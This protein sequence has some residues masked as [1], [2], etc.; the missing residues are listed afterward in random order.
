MCFHMGDTH[1]RHFPRVF[2]HVEIH[3]KWYKSSFGIYTLPLAFPHVEFTY[4]TVLSLL[5]KKKKKPHMRTYTFSSVFPNAEI[6]IFV[7][8]SARRNTQFPRGKHAGIHNFSGIS[9]C[10]NTCGNVNSRLRKY[11][12]I[13]VLPHAVIH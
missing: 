13:G 9:T 7:C 11:T 3:V 12:R 1:F 2:L 6:H 4:P 8:T 10:K 5:K